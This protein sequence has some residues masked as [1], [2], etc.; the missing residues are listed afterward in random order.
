MKTWTKYLSGILA[1]GLVLSLAWGLFVWI[2]VPATA[3]SCAVP[4]QWMMVVLI[5]NPLLPTP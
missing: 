5:W 2:A 3:A 1:I 4:L